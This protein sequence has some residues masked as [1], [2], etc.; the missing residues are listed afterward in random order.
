MHWKCP[1]CGFANYS[2]QPDCGGG[3]GYEK[4]PHRLTLVAAETGKE[5]SVSITTAFGKD[6]LRSFAGGD[7]VY[8]SNPQFVICKD[9]DEGGWFLEHSADAKNP[10]FLNGNTVVATRVRLEATNILSIG[11]EKM[12]LEVLFQ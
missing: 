5:V 7:A 6:L 11:P 10:T 1:S 9:Y 4:I 12:R 2:T 8:A 3:C